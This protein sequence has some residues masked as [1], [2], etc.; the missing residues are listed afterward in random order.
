MALAAPALSSYVGTGGTHVVEFERTVSELADF[1]DVWE[2][3]YAIND[4]PPGRELY[5]RAH[6]L[7]DT[8]NGYDLA[9]AATW[10][11]EVRGASDL[12]DGGAAFF[13]RYPLPPIDLAFFSMLVPPSGDL[14]GVTWRTAAKLL[15]QHQEAEAYGVADAGFHWSGEAQR[16]TMEAMGAL[17]NWDRPK[18]VGWGGWWRGE[19]DLYPPGPPNKAF[20]I[21]RKAHWT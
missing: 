9:T 2:V 18:W 8:C 16:R 19:A 3:A 21:W 10:L 4:S 17:V 5:E 1:V 20:G 7:L 11:Y 15:E 14:Q 12:F 6:E 13:K